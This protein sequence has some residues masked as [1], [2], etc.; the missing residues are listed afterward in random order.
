MIITITIHSY[1]IQQLSMLVVVVVSL[2][3]V[4]G[5]LVLLYL[6]CRCRRCRCRCRCRRVVTVL[7]CSCVVELWV[8][9]VVLTGIGFLLFSNSKQLTVLK[10]SKVVINNDQS[11]KFHVNLQD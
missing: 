11:L 8:V 10:F 4:R 5:F 1:I 9:D 7:F 3:V 6:S 2:V